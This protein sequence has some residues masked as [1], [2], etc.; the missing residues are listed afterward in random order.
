MEKKNTLMLTFFAILFML[1]LFIQMPVKAVTNENM[2]IL[3]KAEKEFIIYYNEICNNEFNFAFSVNKEENEDNL[4]YF[5]SVKDKLQ[6]EKLNVAYVD[7]TIFDKYFKDN[8]AYIWIKDGEG[9][10]LVKAAEVD[11]KA[12]VMT[13][14]MINFVNQ[15]TKRIK[16]EEVNN[17]EYVYNKVWTDENGVKHTVVL[18]QYFVDI[19]KGKTYYYQIVKIPKGDKTSEASTLYDLAEKLKNKIDSKLE[20]FK[21]QS[22]F[23]NLYVKLEPKADDTNWIKT[24]NGEIREPEDT[25]T[26]D[27]YIIW[28]KSENGDEVVQDAKFLE[29][30]QEDK[31]EKEKYRPLE[32]V[33]T[34]Q[35]YDSKA[36]LI[37]FGV[38]ILLI[39]VVLIL[40]KITTQK[41]S[42]H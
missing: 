40:K 33:K 7:E 22:D 35:T 26:G 11:L 28:L 25:V 41:K 24:E 14:E 4:I 16:G 30:Y 20:M 2:T 10:S 27:K 37:A 21:T 31:E 36:L 18:S 38:I 19:E 39:V 17:P 1:T 32:P 15:T 42:K 34:P 12:N 9:K 23:Y 8:K 29:C 3:Q 5:S 6:D 13:D